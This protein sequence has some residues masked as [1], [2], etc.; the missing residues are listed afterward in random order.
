MCKPL[1]EKM[2]H[3]KHFFP[4]ARSAFFC[5]CRFFALS[6]FSLAALLGFVDRRRLGSLA[7]A[8]IR[9]SMRKYA[10]S[11]LILC[12]RSSSDV[13]I[14]SLSPEIRF[15]RSVFKR[16]SSVSERPDKSHRR[17]LNVTFEFTLFTFCPPGPPEREKAASAKVT[18]DCRSKFILICNSCALI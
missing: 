12:E 13:I 17:S 18:I 10:L 6:R 9:A 15:E 1:L 8:A 11:R 2:F 14:I 7:A 16:S 5:A 3:V 4:S